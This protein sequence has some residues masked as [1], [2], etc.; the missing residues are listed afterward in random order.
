M[1]AHMAKRSQVLWFMP[2]M[3]LLAGAQLVA[4]QPN[5]AQNLTDGQKELIALYSELLDNP[6]DIS[7]TLKYAKLA[8]EIGDY[9]A[10]IPPLER[11]LLTNPN[12]TKIMLELGVLYYMLDAHDVARGYFMDVKE[13]AD[14]HEEMVQ[15]ADAYLKRM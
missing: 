4:F 11:L 14:A 5:A 7:N 6:T 15:K 2:F 12:A 3:L 13:Q 8:V 1:V 9:E 10:A